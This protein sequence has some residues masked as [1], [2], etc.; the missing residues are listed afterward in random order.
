MGTFWNQMS[1]RE[2]MITLAGKPGHGEQPRWLEKVANAANIS[3]RSA[4]DLWR[5]DISDHNHRAAVAV[6]HAVE[7]KRTRAEKAALE[8][9]LQT[10]IGG[11]NARDP[12]FHSEDIASLVLAVRALRNVDRT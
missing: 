9:Q 2:A 6:H 1:A 12:D 10:I 3:K 11:L 7:L 5:G 8:A 4:R